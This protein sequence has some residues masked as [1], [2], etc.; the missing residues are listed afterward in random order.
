MDFSAGSALMRPAARTVAAC[1][2][3]GERRWFL[4]HQC[5]PVLRTAL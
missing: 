5:W 2:D 4:G 3:D 1:K